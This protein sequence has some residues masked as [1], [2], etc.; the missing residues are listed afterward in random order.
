MLG[1]VIAAVSGVLLMASWLVGRP[2]PR[3]QA[4][5]PASTK[6]PD[7]G[8]AAWEDVE[9]IA[10]RVASAPP[11]VG[12][13]AAYQDLALE[14]LDEVGRHF[15]PASKQ[16]RLELTLVQVIEISER[17]LRDIRS[18][19]IDAM[20]GGRSLKL[21][22][23]DFA[24][25]ASSFVPSFVHATRASLLVNRIRRW[26]FTPVNAIAYE[27]VNLFDASPAAIATRQ[28]NKIAA[29]LF[30]QRVGTYAI[31]AFS[32][33]ASID[34]TVVEAITKEKPLRILL[35]GPLNAGKSS[36]TNAIFGQERVKR[37]I[38]PCPGLKEE[39]VL[40]RDGAPRA[41]VLDSDGFGGADD[42]AARKRLFEAIETVDLIIAVTSARQAARQLECQTLDD[43]RR[44][45]AGS[46]RRTCPPII[47]AATHVDLL[48]A[49]EWNPPYD[50][51][52]GD[53]PKE[54]SIRQAVDAIATDFQVALDRV[55]PVSLLPDGGYNVEETF[56][57][58]LGAVLPE[59]ERAKFLRVV[60]QSR[61]ADARDR[62]GKA[63]ALLTKAGGAILDAF[64]R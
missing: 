22:H 7:A 11:P 51:L 35:L 52:D 45:F 16:P 26:I 1:L 42:E 59:A 27:A 46:P 19:L 13:I 31:Q 20:P 28:A 3:R 53:S 64:R 9:R 15:H 33:Q 58:V 44:R 39:H 61:S 41:I 2:I 24:R 43:V 8:Q 60:E 62:L 34:L 23:I 32:D 25:R 48:R 36:L 12:A 37:D 4:I 6:W 14:I 54:Q 10:A 55:I 29:D 21:A 63:I 56:L 17:V 30:V 38:L 40:D 50:F 47:V 49:Q 5:P 18:E 57:P